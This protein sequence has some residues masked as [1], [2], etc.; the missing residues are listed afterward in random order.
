MLRYWQIDTPGL[1]SDENIEKLKFGFVCLGLFYIRCDRYVVLLY[2]IIQ[3]SLLQGRREGGE[4][5]IPN[6]LTCS[7]R[8]I[9]NFKF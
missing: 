3:F 7:T 2:T 8:L 1:T 4:S 5:E 9:S 6:L